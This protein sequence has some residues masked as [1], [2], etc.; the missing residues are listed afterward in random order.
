MYEPPGFGFS[1][2]TKLFD[3]SLS[4]YAAV[5]GLLIAKIEAQLRAYHSESNEFGDKNSEYIASMPKTHL[6]HHLHRQSSSPLSPPSLLSSTPIPAHPLNHQPNRG[7]GGWDGA[8]RE[9]KI[10]TPSMSDSSRRQCSRSSFSPSSQESSEFGAAVT[11]RSIMTCDRLR[12]SLVHEQRAYHDLQNDI[13]DY[14]INSK[15][16]P[17]LSR[18]DNEIRK[19]R[20]QEPDW[21]PAGRLNIEHDSTNNNTTNDNNQCTA[22]NERVQFQKFVLVAPCI[23]AYPSMLVAKQHMNEVVTHL[24]LIQAPTITEEVA[25]AK[26]LKSSAPLLLGLGHTW[27]IAQPFKWQFP[28]SAAGGTI[29]HWYERCFPSE[30]KFVPYLFLS[31]TYY[32]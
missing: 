2:P 11:G 5:I 8:D 29:R 24:V 21:R 18:S 30:G 16:R 26:R 31:I 10:R 15:H 3:Y 28:F 9:G 32:A 7:S 23:L 17:M 14:T 6:P 13:S 12:S 4:S 20:K 1:I 25:W 19:K 27:R 22:R